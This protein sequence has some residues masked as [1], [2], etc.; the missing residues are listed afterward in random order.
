MRYLLKGTDINSTFKCY[1]I[2]NLN[3]VH[4]NPNQKHTYFDRLKTKLEKKELVKIH[5]LWSACP[6]FFTC[7]FY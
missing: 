6:C 1:C 4:N 2:F 5:F 7:F 3:E